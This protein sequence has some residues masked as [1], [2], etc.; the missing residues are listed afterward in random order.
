MANRFNRLLLISSKPFE[1]WA[2]ICLSRKLLLSTGKRHHLGVTFRRLRGS[3]TIASIRNNIPH[4]VCRDAFVALETN[5]GFPNDLVAGPDTFRD[6]CGPNPGI[7]LSGKRSIW[8]DSV[9]R[10]DDDLSPSLSIYQQVVE[11]L[12]VE[13]MLV[14]QDLSDAPGCNLKP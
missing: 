1:E 4:I 2:A 8:L 7:R 10:R 3:P 9:T 11:G 14:H 6:G 12:F 13:K 5:L